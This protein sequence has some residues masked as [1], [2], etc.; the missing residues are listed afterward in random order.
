M[1]KREF[2]GVLSC[3]LDKCVVAC[4]GVSAAVKGLWLILLVVGKQTETVFRRKDGIV[5]ANDEFPVLY[6]WMF[7]LR[8]AP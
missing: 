5:D 8:K 2:A 7:L 1:N 3:S 4:L 6:V